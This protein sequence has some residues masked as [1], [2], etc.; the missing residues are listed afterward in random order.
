MFAIINLKTKATP[1]LLHPVSIS[2]FTLNSICVIALT[3][4]ISSRF[5]DYT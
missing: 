2:S 4:I 1:T 3:F 5:M